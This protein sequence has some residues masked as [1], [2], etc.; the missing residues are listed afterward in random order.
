M[1]LIN[2]L[3]ETKVSV[4]ELADRLEKDTSANT[5]M[6]YNEESN[7]SIVGIITASHVNIRK[8]KRGLS[9][10]TKSIGYQIKDDLTGEVYNLEKSQGIHV[11]LVKGYNNG[12]IRI[13]KRKEKSTTYL[14]PLTRQISFTQDDRLQTAFKLDKD[15]QVKIPVELL[16]DKERCTRELWQLIEIHKDKY[17][18]TSI[19]RKK[20]RT[21]II[22]D[23][24]TVLTLNNSNP[25]K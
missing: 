9:N 5:R 7:L 16:I 24:Q 18:E 22:S 1:F 15:G 2:S 14:H 25:F 11:G 4:E 6:G 12:Y 17:K 13:Q 21:E 8:T 3:L 19:S 10:I 23:L 20:S